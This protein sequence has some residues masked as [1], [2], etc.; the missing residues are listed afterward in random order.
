MVNNSKYITPE[1]IAF[2]LSTSFKNKQWEVDTVRTWCM[3]CET[4]Y[5]KDIETM[6]K[7]VGV[8]LRIEHGM[9]LLPCNVWRR[10]DV[11]KNR[12]EILSY[13]CNGAFLYDFH[14][15]GV[16]RNYRDGEYIFIDYA[17]VNID[18]EGE[19]LIV[20]GHEEACKMYCKLQMFEEDMVMGRFPKDVYAQWSELFSG[21]YMAARS[22][23][24]HK[25]R[26]Q[27]D[28]LT[29][30]RANMIPKIGSLILDRD[31]FSE[32]YDSSANST[33]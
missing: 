12:Y 26:K 9:A 33:I 23:Y 3:N 7:F 14:W 22:N 24:Q 17:G 31:Q 30:I 29:I 6:M 8:P 27:I 5:I 4:R 28:N 21:M 18:E 16:R 15:K 11:Y 19:C 25:D 32:Y 1:V 20:K 2:E 13:N 10:L